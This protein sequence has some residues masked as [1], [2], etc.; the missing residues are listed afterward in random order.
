MRFLPRRRD[1][2]VE[3]AAVVD[4]GRDEVTL[5][6]YNVWNDPKHAE[7]RYRAIAGLLAARKPDIM[8]FQEITSTALDVLLSQ[9]WISDRYARAAVVGGDAGDYGMLMLSRIP[10]SRATYTRLPTRQARGFLTADLAVNGTP[11]VVCCIHLDSG[12][13]SGRLRG[14]QLRRIFGALKYA[15]NAVVLGDFNMRD[16]ENSRIKPPYRDAW[17]E[18][19]P[20][21]DGFTEDTSINLMRYDMKD[22][23][24][25]V[26][27]D[28]V[29]LK[30]SRWV[31]TNIAMLGTEP[32]HAELPRVFP[33]DHFGVECR[34]TARNP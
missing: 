21:E 27:F 33:S 6:T 18:L 22:K 14:W 12:K 8:V 4:A 28:R 31:A 29:L 1:V 11:M 17:L 2:P 10:V 9:E 16:G 5:T 23:H 3:P 34:L 25:H 13:S 30:S 32:I 19:R 24:R 7:Q 26:R 20:G 15:Q